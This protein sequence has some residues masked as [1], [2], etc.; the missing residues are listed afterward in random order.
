MTM[1]LAGLGFVNLY[2]ASGNQ[3]N[4]GDVTINVNYLV[5]YFSN[6]NS[7][8]GGFQILNSQTN[9]G[10]SITQP[11][12]GSFKNL[13]LTVAGNTHHDAHGR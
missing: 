4:A 2:N 12:Q 8:A 13:V 1:Q 9:S 10:A 5:A 11:T 6:L 3:A 7:G